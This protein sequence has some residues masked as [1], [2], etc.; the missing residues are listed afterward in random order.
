MG[1]IDGEEWDEDSIG[2]D[3]E[4]ESAVDDLI[5]SLLPGDLLLTSENADAIVKGLEYEIDELRALIA[6]AQHV[7][8]LGTDSKWTELATPTYIRQDGTD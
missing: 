5:S 8:N 2:F 7:L 3:E 6:K 4:D 1:M